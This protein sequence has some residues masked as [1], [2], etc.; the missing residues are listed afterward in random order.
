MIVRSAPAKINLA[1]HVVGQRSDG[2][3]LLDTLV[4]FADIGDTI[5][6]EPDDTLTLSIS[7]PFAAQLDGDADAN[8]VMRAARLLADVAQSSG[9]SCPGAHI[10]LEKALPIA[11]GVGGGSADAAATLHAL[12]D[13]WQLGLDVAALSQIG[14]PLGADIPMCLAAEPARVTGIG[15]HVAPGPRLPDHALLLINPRVPVATPHVFRGL[16]RRDHPPMPELPEAWRDLDHLVDW[17]QPTRNDL[18]PAAETIA[19]VITDVLALMR[20]LPG[21]QFARMSG[22]G[23]TCFGIFADGGAIE[24]ANIVR[25]IRPE[26]WVG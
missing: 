17:L 2:Y 22:S 23:A 6:V 25:E 16:T 13:L 12:N 15:E 4:T 9:R 26:W 8:L 19:P 5:T 7:G 21:C 24:A 18:Q 20:D 3:H 14:L 11:S 1:L 10:G